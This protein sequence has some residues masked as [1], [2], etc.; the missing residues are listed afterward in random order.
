MMSTTWGRI[1]SRTRCTTASTSAGS[2]SADSDGAWVAAGLGNGARLRVSAGLGEPR[3]GD[4]AGLG[5]CIGLTAAD[6]KVAGGGTCKDGTEIEAACGVS[7]SC[8]CSSRL[9]VISAH[10]IVGLGGAA[11]L[12]DCMGL[13]TAG[14]SE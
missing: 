3:L 10:L 1:L 8:A 14:R 4:T 2:G 11:G 6:C 7:T 13:T 12:G 5:D 9:S